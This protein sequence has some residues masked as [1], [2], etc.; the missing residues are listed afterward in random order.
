MER[1]KEGG[2]GGG[3]WRG[4]LNASVHVWAERGGRA[5]GKV[6]KRKLEKY[7]ICNEWKSA[8]RACGYPE[9]DTQTENNKQKGQW[10]RMEL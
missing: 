1:A 3:R 9:G 5:V 8:F 10:N 4:M 2:G 7:E 6:P